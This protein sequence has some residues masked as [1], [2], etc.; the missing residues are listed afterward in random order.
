MQIA[1]FIFLSYE[2]YFN[3]SQRFF[4]TANSFY[5]VFVTCSIAHTDT[6]RSTE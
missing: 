4:N 5:N 6:F 1:P 3:F 2:S